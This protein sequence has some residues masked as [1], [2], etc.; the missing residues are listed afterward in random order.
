MSK[1]QTHIIYIVKRDMTA[2]KIADDDAY[3][4]EQI[5][6]AALKLLQKHDPEKFE[7]FTKLKTKKVKLMLRVVSAEEFKKIKAKKKEDSK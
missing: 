7:L 6:T 2:T 1:E 3:V 5:M 4:Y